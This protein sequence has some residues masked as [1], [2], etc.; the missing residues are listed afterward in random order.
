[1]VCVLAVP[2][3]LLTASD[4]DSTGEP[5]GAS[6]AVCG[7]LRFS[8]TRL[9]SQG[10]GGLP[11]RGR[12]ALKH[13]KI[14]KN[15]GPPVSLELCCRQRRVPTAV[16]HRLCFQTQARK[17]V[18]RSASELPAAGPQL[19]ASH[20]ETRPRKHQPEGLREG[21]ARMGPGAASAQESGVRRAFSA[22]SLCLS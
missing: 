6:S 3:H 1:M 18:Q 11:T 19:A 4:Q 10:A 16:L 20:A 14:P 22:R 21:V 5:A 7:I 17:K 8:L 13:T 9:S 15:K 12:A 2:R